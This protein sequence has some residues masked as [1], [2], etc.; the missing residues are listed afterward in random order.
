MGNEFNNYQ[1]GQVV[2]ATT[3]A[4]HAAN[5]AALEGI[6]TPLAVEETIRAIVKD[7]TPFTAMLEALPTESVGQCEFKY[8]F[9][10]PEKDITSV[11]ATVTADAVTIPVS[12]ADFI[13]P[14]S[15]YLNT[16]TDEQFY[17]SSISGINLTVIRGL[18]SKAYAMKPGDP[19]QFTSI[20]QEEAGAPV[21]SVWHGTEYTTG[22][23]QMFE[24]VS[25]LSD[26]MEYRTYN[27]QTEKDRL[28]R[29]HVLRFAKQKERAFILGKPSVSTLSGKML[30]TTAGVR[31]FA[32][33]Y[34]NYDM[35][36][37]SSYAS[38]RRVFGEVAKYGCKN[39]I[40]VC[41][42]DLA[43]RFST[44]PEVANRIRTT[45]QDDTLGYTI[46]KIKFG[47]GM[48]TLVACS[49][50]DTEGYD[51]EM[52]VLDMSTF[53]KRVFEPFKQRPIDTQGTHVS[54]NQSYERSGLGCNMPIRNARLHNFG[55]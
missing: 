20:A 45:Q 21:Q 44:M 43:E 51:N 10:R 27:G 29:Q 23:C 3:G 53:R 15:L 35:G 33:Q 1:T 9:G 4:V 50:L 6:R 47:G 18:G 11:T 42:F 22:Y 32:R 37:A 24:C 36:H 49:V 54:T 17:V 19:L 40:G 30:Y 13:I 16:R 2:G 14:K 25:S 46:T 41:S 8:Q 31:Y 38:V 55:K 5:I 39:P 7:E 12:N 48:L 26:I 52:L 28:T 34:N